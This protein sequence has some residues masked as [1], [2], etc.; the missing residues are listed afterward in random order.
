VAA[1][2]RVYGPPSHPVNLTAGGDYC[3]LSSGPTHRRTDRSACPEAPRLLEV[4]AMKK[5]RRRC[6]GGPRPAAPLRHRA[7]DLLAL[8]E[9]STGPFFEE[10]L[11]INPTDQTATGIVRVYATAPPWTSRSRSRPAAGTCRSTCCPGRHRRDVG[12]GRHERER[13]PDLRR[14]DDLLE[15][16]ARRAQRRRRRR[17]RRRGYS[18]RAR[19]ATSSAR[20]SCW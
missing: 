8:A 14:A 7:T 9:G 6:R 10:V 12:A 4:D 20:S 13:R 2:E 18:A 3:P 11:A 19:P 16:P 15:R 1:A 17:R 5:L